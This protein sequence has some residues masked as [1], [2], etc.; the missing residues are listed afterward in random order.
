MQKIKRSITE[1][2]FKRLENNPAVALLGARQVGKSTLANMIVGQFKKSVY[3]DLELDSDREKIERDREL[4]LNANADKLICLDEIQHL[5][6]LFKVL[7]GVI[8]SK[9]RNAQFLI[10]GSASRD[11]IKQSSETLAGRIA[12]LE[13]TPF[14]RYEVPD[15]NFFEYW[16]RGGY[17]KS[18][19]ANDDETSFAWRND[20]IKTFL[21]RDLPSLGFRVPASVLKKFWTMLAHSQGQIMNYAKLGSSLDVSIHAIKNYIHILEETLVIR[22]LQPYYGNEKKRLVKS[23]K[24]YI[25]DTGILHSLLRIQDINDLLGHPVVGGSFETLVIENIIT[26]FPRWDAY[27]YRDSTGNEVDLVLEKGLK[28]IAIEIKSSTAPKIEKGFWNS[29]KFLKP[30]EMWCIAQVDTKYPGGDGLWITNLELFL[31]E[32]LS[33]M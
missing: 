28:K 14:L 5:P 3:L 25:R 30:D 8:D 33:E 29:M 24:V 32:K 31:K 4:F 19:L 27:F 6:E 16:L 17:P 21:E 9:E 26:S 13:I 22:V 12:Y 7:R 23:P 11:L 2:L 10:L 18:L 1:K 20:Y 15:T